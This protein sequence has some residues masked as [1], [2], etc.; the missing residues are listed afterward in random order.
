MRR[1]SIDLLHRVVTGSNLDKV[2]IAVPTEE[3]AATVA[4]YDFAYLVTIGD[5]GRPHIT[6]VSPVVTDAGLVVGGLGRKTRANLAARP[7]VTL[8]WPPDS[9]ERYSLIVDGGSVLS[10]DT[11]VVTPTR[12]VLHRPAPRREPGPGCASDCVEIPAVAS[13]HR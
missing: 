12:A 8:V 13:D 1:G 11:L 4:G 6:A 10:G 2:S 9:A 5:D 3:L 7:T